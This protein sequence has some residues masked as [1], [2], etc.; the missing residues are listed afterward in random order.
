MIIRSNGYKYKNYSEWEI[1]KNNPYDYEK[2]GLLK[3]IMSNKIVNA[4]NPILQIILKYIENSLIYVMKNIDHLKHFK[5]YHYY[6]R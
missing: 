4:E 2:Y 6:N 3:H 1:L 5:N